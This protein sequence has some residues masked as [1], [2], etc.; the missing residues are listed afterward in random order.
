MAPYKALYGR[1]CRS[2]IGWFE[3]GD[4][5]LIGQ[6]MVHQA[7]EKVKI[8]QERLKTAQ[9]RQKSYTDVRRKDLEFEVHDWIYLKVSPMKGVMRF[10]KKGKLSPR[11][12]GRYRISKR[13]D[14]IAYE[15]ELSQ[16]LAAVHP[17]F[18]ISMLKKCMGDPSLTIPTKNIGIK[19]NLSYEKIPFHIF[20]RQVCKLRTKEVASIKV[21]WRNQFVE[22][23]NWEA[24]EDMKKRYPYLFAPGEASYQA[25][26]YIKV[27][28]QRPCGV[29][30]NIALSKWKWEMINMDFITGLMRSRRQHDSIWVIVDRMTKSAHFLP[31]KGAQFTASVL[32]VILE[33]VAR[34]LVGLAS[35]PDSSGCFAGDG[36]GKCE[37]WWLG[38]FP[39][40]F[41][42]LFGHGRETMDGSYCCCQRRERKRRTM[43][44]WVVGASPDF[45]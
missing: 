11:Y 44:F 38:L 33:R 6:D 7:M 10:G 22:E 4:A 41:W 23:A 39:V 29:A 31:D 3:V 21:L 36:E 16:E 19:D 40:M 37:Q 5:E 17:V 12:I 32:E 45:G 8:I 30:Q 28:H 13:I 9:S 34:E 25:R 20:Y 24:E 27:E 14:N 18:H 26:C 2:P 1:R 43:D 35:S 15:L 42:R